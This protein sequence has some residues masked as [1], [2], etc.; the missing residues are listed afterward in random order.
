MTDNTS[1][2]SSWCCDNCDTSVEA[3]EKINHKAL[4]QHTKS[5]QLGTVQ[6]GPNGSSRL[7]GEVADN[8]EKYDNHEIGQKEDG[9]HGEGDIDG[10][11][12][13]PDEKGEKQEREM[14]EEEGGANL[15]RWTCNICTV[16][17]NIFARDDHLRSRQHVRE[18]RQ[19]SKGPPTPPPQHSPPPTWHC[20]IYDEGM[21]V[22]H[23]ADHLTTNQHLKRLRNQHSENNSDLAIQPGSSILDHPS[24]IPLEE[25]PI[26]SESSVYKFRN[27]F[28]CTTC[29][30][31]FDFSMQD[32]HLD[33][34]DIWDCAGCAAS[35]H[36]DARDQHLLSD[37]HLTTIN[38]CEG[39]IDDFYCVDCKQ[40]YDLALQTAHFTGPAHRTVSSGSGLGRALPTLPRASKSRAGNSTRI[41]EPVNGTA[42][43]HPSLAFCAICKEW[44]NKELLSGHLAWHCSN[45]TGSMMVAKP[46]QSIHP[47]NLPILQV[48]TASATA[49]VTA[50]RTAEP[51]RLQFVGNAN[52]AAS[53]EYI[54]ISGTTFHCKPCGRERQVV[55][56]TSH[57]NTK[58]HKRSLAAYLAMLPASPPALEGSPIIVPS[59]QPAV[60]PSPSAG[61]EVDSYCTVC[62]K[63][64]TQ[65]IKQHEKSRKHRLNAGVAGSGQSQ[66][67]CDVCKFTGPAAGMGSHMSSR[68][69]LGKAAGMY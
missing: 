67:Y 23:K 62:K 59:S 48:S 25:F 45:S 8:A 36:P 65:S 39:V 55:G 15:M 61:P 53:T 21:S 20:P 44:L 6:D 54:T 31:E 51:A 17:I 30:A 49:T 2:T 69:H 5:S 3:G 28:Y 40:S 41:T 24:P 19:Q 50:V 64:I 42:P 18:L 29:A 60:A 10:E 11:A 52:I 16:T 37:F 38:N 66:F 56:M 13:K 63:H 12:T 34:T 46:P 68:Q 27:T 22:F 7:D 35:M 4:P 1:F 58:S 26:A 14:R 32:N 57:I 47:T 9:D 43:Q 33:S